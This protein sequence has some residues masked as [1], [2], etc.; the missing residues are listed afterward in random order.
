MNNAKQT[1]AFIDKILQ[2]T[3]GVFE[4]FGIYFGARLGY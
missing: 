4:M 2:S 3:R 1:E